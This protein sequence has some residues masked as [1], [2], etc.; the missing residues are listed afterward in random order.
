MMNYKHFTHIVSRFLLNDNH[1]YFICNSNTDLDNERL[2]D[3]IKHLNFNL[4]L[5][6]I[7]NKNNSFLFSLNPASLKSLYKFIIFLYLS[8]QIQTKG[9]MVLKYRSKNR[10]IVKCLLK[11]INFFNKM[12]LIVIDHIYFEDH[13]FISVISFYPYQK[14]NNK[15]F[16]VEAIIP[17]RNEF[18]SLELVIKHLLK[19]GI[20][21]ITIFDDNSDKEILERISNISSKDPRIKLVEVEESHYYNWQHILKL[22]DEQAKLS[23]ADFI[24]RCDADEF[25]ISPDS[26]KN[27]RQFFFVVNNERNAYIDG[28]VV[29]LYGKNRAFT[30][31]S[32][33]SF[34]NIPKDPNFLYCLRAWKNNHHIEELDQ[35]GGHEAKNSKNNLF[36]A[37]LTIFHAPYRNLQ[38]AQMKIR[39]RNTRG[40]R[41]RSLRNWHTHT[42][43]VSAEEMLDVPNNSFELN[44]NFMAVTQLERNFKVKVFIDH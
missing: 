17:H 14:Q 4:F 2:S 34:A 21:K 24:V 23:K 5:K 20:D 36:F 28:T 27:L 11:I 26:N 18:E 41:E 12:S 22:I 3:K 38:Q 9:L 8:K 19:Q 13:S 37:N 42:L 31:L 29:N 40:A 1:P 16:K 6:Y 44:K 25:L 10:L 32:D 15:I 30:S 7:I 39:D 43:N 33:A 35:F